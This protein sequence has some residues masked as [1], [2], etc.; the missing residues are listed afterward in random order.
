MQDL[1]NESYVVNGVNYTTYTTFRSPLTPDG[2]D[3][4]VEENGFD[5][6]LTPTVSV[7]NFGEPLIPEPDYDLSDPEY[8]Q[9]MEQRAKKKKK[10]VSFVMNEEMA[11]KLQ[12]GKT[13]R[14]DSILK[15][16]SGGVRPQQQQQHCHHNVPFEAASKTEKSRSKFIE[17]I[18]LARLAFGGGKTPKPQEAAVAKMTMTAETDRVRIAVAP[19]VPPKMALSRSNSMACDHSSS[20]QQHHQQ[21]QQLHKSVSF[22]AEKNNALLRSHAAAPTPGTISE[23]ALRSARSQLK[24]SR[25]FPNELNVGGGN[26][27]GNSEEGDNS[28]SGVSSDQEVTTVIE[29][30]RYVTYLPVE[31]KPKA[32]ATA[33]WAATG[34]VVVAAMDNASESSDDVDDRGW[35]AAESSNRRSA[36]FADL[37]ADHDSTASSVSSASSSTQVTFNVIKIQVTSLKLPKYLLL[38]DISDFVLE[39]D[40]VGLG[41]LSF[42]LRLVFALFI[43]IW[44]I[45]PTYI[46]LPEYNI[47]LN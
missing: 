38:N 29:N 2:D 14:Q 6:D 18:P 46:A 23:N 30:G 42:V 12:A 35:A 27:N 9:M 36:A 16:R 3:E 19:D 33:A 31:T 22:S 24:A 4:D 26:S 25:S 5:P 1:A 32:K 34:K 44:G 17:K 10:S 47:I 15:D 21:Q 8:A 43:H 40:L 11:A 7:E 37:M 41:N 39:V 13:T 28:S 45:L 20:L